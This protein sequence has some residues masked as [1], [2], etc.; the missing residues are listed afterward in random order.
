MDGSPSTSV[1]VVVLGNLDDAG[2]AVDA[3]SK[4]IADMYLPGTALRGLRPVPDRDADETAT[5]RRALI[6]LIA[7]TA[8]TAVA[9][10]RDAAGVVP[11]LGTR[12]PGSARERLARNGVST[13][14]RARR[15]VVV[16]RS[17]SVGVKL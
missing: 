7:L 17:L 13:I 8:L 2:L 1:T 10:G 4:D 14:W 9:A 15:M 12:L 11:G 6:A 3:M 5:L 16:S